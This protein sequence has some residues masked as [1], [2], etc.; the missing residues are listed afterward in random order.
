MRRLTLFALLTALVATLLPSQEVEARRGA[1]ARFRVLSF[2]VRY[3]FENDG[4]NRW[5]NRVDMVA[6]VIDESL[7]SVVCLQ[8]DKKHQVDDL[9]SRLTRFQFV[10]RGRNASGSGERCSIERSKA[11]RSFHRSRTSSSMRGNTT[12]DGGL[13]NFI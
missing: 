1:K 4:A 13:V 10:G 5:N 8:E 12:S 3:D 2:N 11:R 9:K 7:A 6:H